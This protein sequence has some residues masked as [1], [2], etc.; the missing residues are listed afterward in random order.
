MISP[1]RLDLKEIAFAQR[2]LSVLL[3]WSKALMFH[4]VKYSMKPEK[5]YIAIF[6]AYLM[7]FFSSGEQVL[8]SPKEVD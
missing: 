4:D 5:K 2:V 7:G 1:P 3:W 8:K 6:R